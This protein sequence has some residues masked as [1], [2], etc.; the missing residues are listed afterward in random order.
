MR[1]PR[2]LL[3]FAASSCLVVLGTPASAQS[4]CGPREQL[5]KS[6]GER[7]R[8]APVGVGVMQPNQVLELFTSDAGSWTMVVTL[9]NG[10]SCLIAA[11]E[12]WNSI[13]PVKGT[14]T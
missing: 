4:Q 5:V 11:G 10:T 13:I 14:P 3:L 2:S 12:S 6:L 8:E 1:I 7:Y 9:P